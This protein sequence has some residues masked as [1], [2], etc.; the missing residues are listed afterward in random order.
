V[1]T[2]SEFSAEDLDR[3]LKLVHDHYPHIAERMREANGLLP[4]PYYHVNAWENGGS[5]YVEL[6]YGDPTTQDGLQVLS[7]ALPQIECTLLGFIHGFNI[8]AS[9]TPTPQMLWKKFIE[10][11]NEVDVEDAKNFIGSIER[12]RRLYLEAN[13]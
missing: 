13:Q 7:F 6:L 10:H 3:S 9:S 1:S 4:T 8:G 11:L 12:Y 5:I 2:Y